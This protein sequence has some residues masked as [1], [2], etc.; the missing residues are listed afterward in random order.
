VRRRTGEVQQDEAGAPP[1]LE[2]T[3]GPVGLSGHKRL[4][5]L[6]LRRFLDQEL[7]GFQLPDDD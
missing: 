6:P 3:E 5:N 2:A 7:V 4:A 1:D